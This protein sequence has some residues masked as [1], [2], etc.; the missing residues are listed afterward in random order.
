MG[1]GSTRYT[2]ASRP[3]LLICSGETKLHDTS[4]YIQKALITAH[5][6][7]QSLCLKRLNV[8]ILMTISWIVLI[9]LAILIPRYTRSNWPRRTVSLF[10]V[11]VQSD[12]FS[13][14]FLGA[15]MWLNVSY[16]LKLLSI[17]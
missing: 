6:K 13:L 10:R 4:G 12:A 15:P 16:S 17:V 3:S 5:G 14:Q 9:P 7:N 11:C 2:V 1:Y 8:A